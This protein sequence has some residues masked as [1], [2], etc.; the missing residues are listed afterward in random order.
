M[1]ITKWGLQGSVASQNSLWCCHLWTIFWTLFLYSLQASS[2]L[3]SWST[4]LTCWESSSHPGFFYSLQLTQSDWLP[5]LY[6]GGFIWHE[7]W[8]RRALF[9]SWEYLLKNHFVSA[10]RGF[11]RLGQGTT[12]C[13]C[14]KAAQH[15]WCC[16]SMSLSMTL[17]S[18]PSPPCSFTII[19]PFQTPI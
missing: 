10:C 7:G 9:S 16:C 5:D 1:F 19:F 13:F 6:C 14:I 4:P 11:W 12:L 18:A 17:P 3:L 8:T 15:W 2:T